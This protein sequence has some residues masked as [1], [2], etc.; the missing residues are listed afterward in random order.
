M[1]P[2]APWLLFAACFPRVE[3]DDAADGP[4]READ[5]DTDA[6]AD[7]DSDTDAGH[8][9]SI[10]GVDPAEGTD[11]GGQDVEIEGA[12]FDDRTRVWFD[13]E[14]ADVLDV[15]ADRLTVRTP[16][17]AAG[18]ADVAVGRGEPEDTLPDAF[19]YWE[20]A[21]GQNLAFALWY[22]VD[23]GDGTETNTAFVEPLVPTAMALHERWA[24]MDSCSGGA[25]VPYAAWDATIEGFDTDGATY[26][27]TRDGEQYLWSSSD[28]GIWPAGG[29]IGLSVDGGDDVPSFVTDAFIPVPSAPTVTTP[30]FSGGYETWFDGSS[31]PV[32]W[33]GSGNGWVMIWLIGE[34]D[35]DLAM[36]CIAEDDG[37]F[38]IPA[39]DM[40][41]FGA[42]DYVFVV[43]GRASLGEAEVWPND[44]VVAGGAMAM[45]YAGYL[46]VWF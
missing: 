41:L 2:F 45:T 32:G 44:G 38:T 35:A 46:S 10:A 6:D 26:R 36:F 34:S 21:G 29:E 13:G 3:T 23:W 24:D 40:A 11:A 14:E 9:P 12:D 25:D 4:G 16:A 20:D 15:T 43:V 18:E 17:G 27:M 19:R 8:A 5:A 42:E 33:S 22:N 31:L 37:S 28:V 1:P 7:A 39:A 30:R